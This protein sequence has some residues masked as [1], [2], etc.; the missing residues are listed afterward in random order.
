[1]NI[2]N[3][4]APLTYWLLIVMWVYILFFYLRRILS[5][6]L[7]PVFFTPLLILA[8]DAFRTLVESVYFGAW[9]TSAAGLLPRSV[10]DF[11][12]LPQNVIIPK[13][14]NVVVAG[15]VIGI[16]LKRYIPE[17]EREIQ[18]RRAYTQHLEAEVAKRTEELTAAYAAL[19]QANAQLKELDQMKSNFIDI[20]SHELR[21]PLFWIG[22]MLSIIK[23]EISS[24]STELQKNVDRAIRG[25]HR[26]EKLIINTLKVMEGE[27]YEKHLDLVVTPMQPLIL[28]AL[29]AV[30]P[31]TQ[32]RSQQ[33]IVSDLQDL[34]PVEVDLD[35]IQDV[36]VNLL[37]N[38]IKFTPD[39]GK[40]FIDVLQ[41][42]SQS[43]E[44]HVRDEGVGIDETDRPHIF[45][46]FFTG[47]DVLHHTSGEYEFWGKGF[48]LGLAIVKKFIEMHG[49]RVGMT[50]VVGKGSN[51]YFT[52]PRKGGNDT[53]LK[54][55]GLAA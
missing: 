18:R 52:I 38:A 42:D 1:M 4:L 22:G 3:L 44:V 55:D 25:A 51:F 6:K 45:N 31:F 29:S 40:I 37:M 39:E 12:I 7:H 36:L 9:Y 43:V 15:L 14:F 53:Q 20:T 23:K 13:A 19:T 34:P 28:R 8:I 27:Q 26:L 50:S 54:Q 21:T 46:K 17:E 35:K 11:L 48:G 10:H 5:K 41:P 49:G 33:I 47:M 24:Q 32:L 2:F 30:E 16:L